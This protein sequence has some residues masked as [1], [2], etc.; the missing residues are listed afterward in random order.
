[1]M[2]QPAAM[3]SPEESSQTRD[4]DGLAHGAPARTFRLCDLDAK[5]SSATE[6]LE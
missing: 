6:R 2:G 4:V 5:M 3:I 1:M